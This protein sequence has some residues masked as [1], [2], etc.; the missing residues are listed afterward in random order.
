MKIARR[1]SLLLMIG[2]ILL[3]FWVGGT[4]VMNVLDP[5]VLPDVLPLTPDEISVGLIG[6]LVVPT[7][8]AI[9][10]YLVWLVFV[11]QPPRPDSPPP[12]SDAP[13]LPAQLIPA[14]PSQDKIL[15]AYLVTM[16]ELLMSSQSP[17]ALARADI[18][19][20]VFA[21]TR[22]VL[23]ALD[24]GGRGRVIQ[25]LQA[26]H[27]LR[28]DGRLSLHE[29]DLSEVD[30]RFSDLRCANLSG[31]NLARAHLVGA[32]LYGANLT[33]ANLDQA[34]LR[35]AQLDR[36]TLRQ[37]NLCGVKLHRASLRGAC[38]EDAALDRVNLWQADLIGAD[39]TDE[40][41]QTTSFIGAL[42]PDGRQYA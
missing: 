41:L 24:P 21:R 23:P 38:L 9:A 1:I 40:Q 18:R 31:V 36:A 26:A 5:K 32:L 12:P 4:V 29:F 16:S 35:L 34:D 28:G 22:Q 19:S 15:D 30:L 6:N 42:L 39:I 37:A 10:S 13:P 14:T 17:D 25:F 27:F 3:Y 33:N 20:L 8:M 7:T 11:R 2:S